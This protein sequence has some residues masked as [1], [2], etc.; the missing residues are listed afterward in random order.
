MDITM[1]A[2]RT[3]IHVDRWGS[4]GG[5]RRGLGSRD[6]IGIGLGLWLRLWF[7]LWL[8]FGV[9]L[10]SGLG[11]WPSFLPFRVSDIDAPL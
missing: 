6:G 3:Q 5:I 8:W 7:G 11:S 10:W 4:G 2:S 9:W 1:T